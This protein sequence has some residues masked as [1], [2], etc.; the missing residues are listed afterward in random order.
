MQISSASLFF[1]HQQPLIIGGNEPQYLLTIDGIA[2]HKRQEKLKIVKIFVS[3]LLNF[4][5][6]QATVPI[7]TF[8]PLKEGELKNQNI[9][10]F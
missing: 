9:S 4:D 3:R 7:M 10:I 6:S 8:L 1:D 5:G 2:L